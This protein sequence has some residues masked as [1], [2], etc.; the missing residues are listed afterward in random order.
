VRTRV[1]V[2]GCGGIAGLW[3]DALR[4]R[5]D[6]EI[7]ALVDPVE[8]SAKRLANLY[9]VTAPVFGDL[10]LA[11]ASEPVDVV[12]NIT[13]PEMHLEVDLLALEAGCHVFTEKPVA[14]TVEEGRR[15]RDAARAAGRS[16]SVMQNRRFDPSA[17][18]IAA[19]VA[20]GA[21]GRPAVVAVDYFMR[22]DFGG[23]RAEMDNPL[24]LDMA[25]HHFDQSRQLGG[26]GNDAVRV[27]AIEVNPEG[28]PFRGNAV[29]VCT[30][31]RADGSLLSY[32]GSWATP[33]LSTPWA[34]RWRIAGSR[35]TVT[36]DGE[37]SVRAEAMG[38]DGAVAPLAVEPSAD[39]RARRTGHAGCIDEMLDA[40]AEGRPAETDVD[41]NLRS[42]AMVEAA[43]ESA[44]R[45]QPVEVPPHG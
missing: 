4:T 30:F 10:S 42:L 15:I 26:S 1:A 36:W 12:C 24:L 20:S 40:V 35:G 8:A 27:T 9:D 21:I 41:D 13:P 3:I 16:V 39:S 29:A 22:V 33:G 31:E 7:A 38:A 6:V 17:R 45:R 19:L 11:L 5:D 14:P 18:A 25:I 37:Q 2:A 28:S 34:A 43:V 23:F 32:R 44:R